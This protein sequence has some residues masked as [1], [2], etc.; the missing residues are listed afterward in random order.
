MKLKKEKLKEIQLEMQSLEEAKDRYFNLAN[1]KS[2]LEKEIYRAEKTY[3]KDE[4]ELKF[5]FKDCQFAGMGIVPI[6]GSAYF[7]DEAEAKEFCQLIS[8]RY[9]K[10]Y[11]IKDWKGE[12]EYILKPDYK[13]DHDGELINLGK[14]IKK[15][16]E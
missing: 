3:R 10:I 1:E 9:Y 2:K 4:L 6:E 7:Y 13:Y 16:E 5:N 14:F 12:G 15:E 11:F 8:D